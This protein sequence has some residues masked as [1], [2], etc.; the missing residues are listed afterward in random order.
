MIPKKIIR[1]NNMLH[2]GQVNDRKNLETAEM[3]ITQP[4]KYIV[5]QIK[6]KERYESAYNNEKLT[7]NELYVKLDPIIFKPFIE[8]ASPMCLNLIKNL[9]DIHFKYKIHPARDEVRSYYGNNTIVQ[10]G[11]PET[12]DYYAYYNYF[13]TRRYTHVNSPY[14]CTRNLGFPSSIL[15]Y[16]KLECILYAF[17]YSETYILLYNDPKTGELVNQYIFNPRRGKLLNTFLEFTTDKNAFNKRVKTIVKQEKK[18]AERNQERR[19][20]YLNKVGKFRIYSYKDPYMW[21]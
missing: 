7:C 12:I 9:N 15:Y 20:R 2:D 10:K 1:I 18:E 17:G 19:Q 8:L 11:R 16:P 6:T 13:N 21:D 3:P 5:K 4:G 14:T